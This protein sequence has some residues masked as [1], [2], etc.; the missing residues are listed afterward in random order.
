[1]TRRLAFTLMAL[2]SLTPPVS[3]QTCTPTPM[4]Y[5]T[6]GALGEG[7][8]GGQWV[9]P[10]EVWKIRAAGIATDDGR[11]LEWMLQI[12]HPVASQGNA[13]C[14][15]IPLHRQT[16]VA[17]GTPVLALDREVILTEGERLSARVNSIAPDKK[18][19]LLYVGWRFP[20]ACTGRLVV[21]D[22]SESGGAL[23]D[24]TAMAAAA[25]N[26]AAALSA[27]AQSTP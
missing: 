17:A 8:V 3:A 7:I 23:P 21:A 5:L 1:M 27:L 26:A 12:E 14:W 6:W 24:F 11:P 10:G 2:L 15:L 16:G 18:M 9:P 19:A 4:E 20:A 13:C 22:A 25:T